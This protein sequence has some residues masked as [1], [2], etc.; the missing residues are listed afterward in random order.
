MT[1]AGR[2]FWLT[3]PTDV[4]HVD[5]D[6]LLAVDEA[7]EGEGEEG[8]GSGAAAAAARTS[9]A[10]GPGSAAVASSDSSWLPAALRERLDRVRAMAARLAEAGA[11]GTA[12]DT[13]GTTAGATAGAVTDSTGAAATLSTLRVE[14]ELRRVQLLTAQQQLRYACPCLGAAL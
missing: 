3:D 13:T 1:R 8:A 10:G 12:G 7:P 14:L 2:E 5:V 11:G 4:A 6:V 9:A